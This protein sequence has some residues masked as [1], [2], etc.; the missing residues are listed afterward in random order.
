MSSPSY[1][2]ATTFRPRNGAPAECYW[3]VRAWC[4]KNG[5]SLSDVLNA[6]MPPLAYYL[7][8][9]SIVDPERS[10]ATVDLMVG[11]VEILHVFNGKCYPLATEIQADRKV[12][13]LDEIQKR[14]DYWHE[15]N[16]VDPSEFDKLLLLNQDGKKE[17][18]DKRP[19]ISRR[20]R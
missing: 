10:M 5:F 3:R 6:M 9:H 14:I 8:N 1:T 2:E 19:V 4:E 16:S 15:R 18:S 7:E 11:P 12:M 17:N 13:D 20:K